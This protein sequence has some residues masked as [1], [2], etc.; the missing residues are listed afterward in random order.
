MYRDAKPLKT[1][2]SGSCSVGTE[3]GRQAVVSGFTVIYW[4]WT[5]AK[6][7]RLKVLLLTVSAASAGERSSRIF[8]YFCWNDSGSVAEKHRRTLALSCGGFW[9]LVLVSL[10]SSIPVVS[11][12]CF[13]HVLN[14]NWFLFSCATLIAIAGALYTK[15]QCILPELPQQRLQGKQKIDLSL[16]MWDFVTNS[17]LCPQDCLPEPGCKRNLCLVTFVS[18]LCYLE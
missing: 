17:S 10:F 18:N 3:W 5:T 12:C 13:A 9:T 7:W 4:D 15:E 14:K 16:Q 6:K 8:S 2:V 1:N 11:Q